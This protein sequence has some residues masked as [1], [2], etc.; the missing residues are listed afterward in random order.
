MSVV[1]DQ[2]STIKMGSDTSVAPKTTSLGVEAA[3]EDPSCN[4]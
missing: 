2:K 3:A 4:P 1:H